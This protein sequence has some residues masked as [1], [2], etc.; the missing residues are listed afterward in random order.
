MHRRISANIEGLLFACVPCARSAPKNEKT[1]RPMEHGLDFELYDIQKRFIKEARSVI[2]A[3]SVGIFSSPTGTGKTLS[4]LCSVHTYLK[5]QR[6]EGADHA[7]LTDENIRL[8]QI[9]FG[10]AQ[11]RTTVFYCSRTHS[12]LQQAV[13]ELRRLGWKVNA[14]VVGSRRGLCVNS[15]V[16]TRSRSL[17][18][19]NELCRELVDGGRCVHYENTDSK[20]VH[21]VVDVED[22]LRMGSERRMCPYF[23]ARQYAGACEIVFLPYSLLFSRTGRM[24]AN[25]DVDNAIVIVDE[26]HN[27]YEAVISMNTVTVHR[28]ILKRCATALQKHEA[29]HGTQMPWR[30]RRQTLFLVSVFKRLDAFLEKHCTAR[31]TENEEAAPVC[32]FLCQAG[33]ESHNFLGLDECV[34]ECRIAEQLEAAGAGLRLQ[35]LNIISFLLLL[36]F[37]DDAGRVFFTRTRLRFTPLDPALY[38]RD[39]L[40]CRALILAGGTMEP[41]DHLVRVFRGRECRCFSFGAVC[42]NFE[43]FA[44]AYGPSRQELRVT[45]ENRA[46]LL[47]ELCTAVCGLADAVACGGVVCFL[48][49]RALLDAVREQAFDFGREV[50]YDDS[51]FFR[52]DLR[53]QSAIL[54]AVVGGRLSEGINFSDE[55][56]RLL[57]VVGVPYP[58]ITAEMRERAKH[59]GSDYPMHVAMRAVNQAIGRALRH[60]GDYAAI[61]LL[62]TR[63]GGLTARLSPWISAGLRSLGFPET[64]AAVQG[65]LERAGSGAATE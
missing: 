20:K 57:V 42:S 37:S 33:L 49:S 8:T 50:F 54:M 24:S 11:Q 41:S 56:C 25:I 46:A 43:A 12:Q 4:L 14:T 45:F 62:D 26:A 65:F 61:V 40:A 30:T 39:V 3:G 64:L 29:A 5:T 22:L 55:L 27:I 6:T 28:A 32:E 19:I 9:L 1:P 31:S 48:P 35:L 21:G 63:Y 7:G 47:P 58:L 44:V 2:E 23:L 36:T 16:N 13:G 52:F 38:F 60:A 10:S 59:N 34:R 53:T 18:E 15:R 51:R 17:D